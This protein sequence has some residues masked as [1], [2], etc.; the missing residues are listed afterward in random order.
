[1]RVPTS[2]WATTK[3]KSAGIQNKTCRNYFIC[4]LPIK[5]ID[6][7]QCLVWPLDRFEHI[8]SR[9]LAERPCPTRRQ[10]I[11]FLN[12]R[13]RRI[14]TFDH[15][16]PNGALYQTEL[17]PGEKLF[18]WFLS[19]T[20]LSAQHNLSLTSLSPGGFEPTVSARLSSGP[21]ASIGWGQR[22]SI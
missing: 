16:A 18:K 13:D 21:T 15:S 7:N 14:R 6:C 20:K 3:A 12:S 2:Q 8:V 11:R 17:H 22:I 19:N 4:L 10:S 1:M 9:L 5:Y